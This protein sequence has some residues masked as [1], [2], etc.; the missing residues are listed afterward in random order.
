MADSSGGVPS[1]QQILDFVAG[2][3]SRVGKREIARHFKVKGDDRAALKELLR[4]MEA[5]GAIG[6][7]GADLART[8]RD[9]RARQAAPRRARQLTR[10][11]RRQG[12]RGAIDGQHV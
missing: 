11:E 9:A 3:Q 5:E 10:H 12:R 8:Q 4:E 7:A 2:A 1:R 6:R